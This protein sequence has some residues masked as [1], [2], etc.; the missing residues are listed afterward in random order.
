MLSLQRNQS[1]SLSKEKL[2]LLARLVKKSI[3]SAF[4][5]PSKWY[6]WKEKGGKRQLSSLCS[7]YS[8]SL[9]QR[10]RDEL[11]S[12]PNTTRTLRMNTCRWLRDHF[13]PTRA[14]TNRVFSFPFN[15]EYSRGE[16]APAHQRCDAIQIPHHPPNTP[17]TQHPA[18]P[19]QPRSAPGNLA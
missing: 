5:S 17:S 14:P 19:S 15:P 16:P 6:S 13:L 3:D 2:S 12:D 11:V 18:C 1:H 4:F 9:K 7:T 10:P 8:S